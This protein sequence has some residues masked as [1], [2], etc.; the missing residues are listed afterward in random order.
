[1]PLAVVRGH[2]VRTLRKSVHVRDKHDSTYREVASSI[3]YLSLALGTTG[4]ATAGTS[5]HRHSSGH[6]RHQIENGCT[7]Q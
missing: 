5:H 2:L 1:M 7:N 3:A 6:L 4:I